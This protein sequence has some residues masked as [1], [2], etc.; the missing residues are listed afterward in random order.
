MIWE[1]DESYD[2]N[3]SWEEFELAYERCSNDKNGTEP[4]QLYFLI[5]FCLHTAA[6][7]AAAGGQ[8]VIKMKVEDAR[9]LMYLQHGR[10]RVLSK[11]ARLDF[12]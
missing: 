6:G 12:S 9:R 11:T 4:R 2:N 8:E 10:V 3:V 1:V 5:L 7:S